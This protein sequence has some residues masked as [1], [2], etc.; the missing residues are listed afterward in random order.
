MAWDASAY[1][2]LTGALEQDRQPFSGS[3]TTGIPVMMDRAVSRDHDSE[4][5]KA[6]LPI[7]R[8]WPEHRPVNV[9][10]EET[11]AHMLPMSDLRQCPEYQEKCIC[12]KLF[13][14][15]AF[16]LKF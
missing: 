13:L 10:G 4:N 3:P 16:L 1:K 9:K 2:Q 11:G 14:R 5:N 12:T 7:Q 6:A 8:Q 15:T